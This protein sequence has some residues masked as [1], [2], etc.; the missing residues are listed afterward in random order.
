L[1]DLPEHDVIRKGGSRHERAVEPHDRLVP[2]Q[3]EI[4]GILT[5]I[6]GLPGATPFG[7][8]LVVHL[9]NGVSLDFYAQEGEVSSQHY[10]F[11]TSEDDFEQI[12]AR[13]FGRGLPFW[14]LPSKQRAG[15]INRNDGGRGVYFENPDGH[16]LEVITRPYGGGG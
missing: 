6:L 5:E 11:L 8:M 13:I 12:L 3:A 16:L 9:D 1:E 10:A 15:E 7:A 4:G 14:A 2:R